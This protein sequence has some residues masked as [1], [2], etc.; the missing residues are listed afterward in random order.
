VHIFNNGQGIW[1]SSNTP[2]GYIAVRKFEWEEVRDIGAGYCACENGAPLNGSYSNTTL[3]SGQLTTL[4][5]DGGYNIRSQVTFS[6]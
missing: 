5:A 1:L 3:P 6:G 2:W 4:E